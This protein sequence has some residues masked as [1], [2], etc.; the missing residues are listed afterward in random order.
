M[1]YRRLGRSGLEV[2]PLCLGTMMFGDRTD[3]ATS[4]RIIGAAQ[5]AGIN[6]IDTADKYAEGESERIVGPAIRAK[7]RTW[8]LATKVGNPMTGRP[9]DGGSSRRWILQACDDSLARLGTDYIDIYYLH[10]DDL[11]T[12][13]EES[14]RAIGDLIRA[15]KIR[16][17]GVSNFRGWR[18]AEV[19]HLCHA[20][21]VPQPVVCQP[22]YNLLNRTPEVE[23]LAAC[24][25]Y[26]IG[27][28][29]YS[30]IARGVLT[31]KYSPET[32]PPQDS[33][34]AR[35]DQRIMET[36]FREQSLRIAQRLDA[37][38]RATG[39]TLLQ[40]AL[41]W[42]WANRVVS[43]VIAGPRTM[44]QWQAYVGAIGTA[45]TEED[46]KLV[47]S[48]VTPGHPSTPGYNDPQYPFFGRR[49]Q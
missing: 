36:E 35:R 8:I 48:L 15:G 34:A 21:S 18:I 45:W 40:F 3:A 5:D 14:V 41:A 25:H 7:R 2:A 17:F 23:I 1:Q 6:F 42:L 24:D 37:H 22:H 16:Y 47:D 44:E 26:G 39:R 43:S 10:K 28:A 31:G 30:P 49:L 4:A 13:L 11:V 32:A 12:P 9:H 46:E 33:R 38:A 29:P 19:M 27:V 20:L